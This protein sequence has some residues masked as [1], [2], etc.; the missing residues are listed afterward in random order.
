MILPSSSC[1]SHSLSHYVE[2]LDMLR[3][4]SRL[5]RRLWN[6]HEPK[7]RQR[8][9]RAQFETL[10]D[11]QLLA[12]GAT[13]LDIV[14]G[15]TSSQLANLTDVNGKLYFTAVDAAHGKE[16]WT[17]NGTLAGTAL[18]KDI[19]PGN[20]PSDP[21]SLVNF[22]GSLYFAANDGANGKEL[23]KSDGTAAGTVRV[24]NIDPGAASSLPYNLTPAGNFLYFATGTDPQQVYRTDGTTAGTV[25]LM[26][27]DPGEIIRE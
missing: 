1:S 17:S 7:V 27:A 5:W 6:G 4:L 9:V 15:S 10:E 25:L 24:A 2:G 23:W 19:N 11:R 16:L 3:P 22:K 20:A 21:S 13:L 12:F 26:T 18:V 8:R 14:P